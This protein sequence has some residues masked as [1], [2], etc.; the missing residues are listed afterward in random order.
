MI[1]D[2]PSAGVVLAV[3]AAT[4]DVILD[5]IGASGIDKRPLAGRIAVGELGLMPDHVVDT[6]YHGGIEQAI[7]AYSEHE[8]LRWAE[9]LGRELPSGWFGENL[10]IDGLPTTDAVVGERW[11]IG[12][13]GLVV[14]T[15]IPR[16]PCRTF[17]VWAEERR[18]VKRFLDRADTGCYLRVVTPGSVGAG[19]AVHIVRRPDH[20]VTVRDLVSGTTADADALATLLACEDLGP[21][22]RRE[23]SRKLA[24]A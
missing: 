22:V 5:T 18:W 13:D 24:H 10:R 23:A 21:K 17:A 6:K 8:A 11:E 12:G 9:E 20:R 1:A 3:C 14:E 15:T 16:T 4:D 19:D 7:Y 2:D